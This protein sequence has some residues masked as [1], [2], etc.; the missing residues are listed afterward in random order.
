MEKR[1]DFGVNIQKST[2]KLT[3]TETDLKKNIY[4]T[5]QKPNPN[6]TA[7]RGIFRDKS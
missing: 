3:V 1:G 4:I 2:P 5:N 7:K 6:P